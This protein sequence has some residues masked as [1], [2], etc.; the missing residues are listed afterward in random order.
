M[1]TDCCAIDVK[2]IPLLSSVWDESKRYEQQVCTPKYW[3]ITFVIGLIILVLRV[4]H[5]HKSASSLALQNANLENELSQL[6]VTHTYE[7]S[8]YDDTFVL[9][10]QVRAAK[11]KIEGQKAELGALQ[12]QF[13]KL[14]SKYRAM[15]TTEAAVIA[16]TEASS[17]WWLWGSSNTV[18]DAGAEAEVDEEVEEIEEDEEVPEF[19][20]PESEMD[21]DEDMMLKKAQ[22]ELKWLKVKAD[23]AKGA[24]QHAKAH[25]D[26]ME[27]DFEYQ[28]DIFAK[29]LEKAQLES[30][31][32]VFS[33]VQID[34]GKVLKNQLDVTEKEQS[35][36]EA[37]LA[38]V[39][40]PAMRKPHE[41][42]L[43]VI[44]EKL[45]HLIKQKEE[46]DR[47]AGI[48]AFISTLSK[49][50]NEMLDGVIDRAS[51]KAEFVGEKVGPYIAPAVNQ[52]SYIV[53]A[54]DKQVSPA[55]SKISNRVSR[56]A[57]KIKSRVSNVMQTVGKAKRMVKN[58]VNGMLK[59]EEVDEEN[60]DDEDEE[61]D[62][63]EADVDATADEDTEETKDEK[64]DE[65]SETDGETDE[66]E[67]TEE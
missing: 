23:E 30:K 37:A 52:A 55:V 5:L 28:K 51:Q 48:S 27:K 57:N 9:V 35:E 1:L 8:Q 63:E 18:D 19:E 64:T 54:I 2:R 39:P 6:K 34:F 53:G 33:A 42:K 3:S 25:L 59:S 36:I 12:E 45:D 15:N 60:F 20:I 41:N 14:Y 61:A 31:L 16:T 38:K 49:P 10:K 32:G 22:N 4:N 40:W 29:Q 50:L 47:T 13:D 11:V 66:E 65:D 58:T 17:S 62:D 46:Y 44:K 43:A 24:E 26:A 56:N 67:K 7:Q 21:G